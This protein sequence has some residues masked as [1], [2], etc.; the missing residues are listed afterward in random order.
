MTC[1]AYQYYATLLYTLQVWAWP[2][3]VGFSVWCVAQRA[4]SLFRVVQ[5]DTVNADDRMRTLEARI[6]IEV[7]RLQQANDLANKH[8]LEWESA[9]QEIKDDLDA[10]RVA[11]MNT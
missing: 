9:Q 4:E 8:A 7:E 2:A 10:M 5:L 1:N 11:S 3:A 6:Q